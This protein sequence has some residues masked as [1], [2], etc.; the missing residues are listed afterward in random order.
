[1]SLRKLKPVELRNLEQQL[2]TNRKKFR[3]KDSKIVKRNGQ[4][5]GKT[6]YIISEETKNKLLKKENL[7]LKDFCKLYNNELDFVSLDGMYNKLTKNDMVRN[8]CYTKGW[9]KI[10]ESQRTRQGVTEVYY[11]YSIP[12]HHI[13]NLLQFCTDYLSNKPLDN[14]DEIY[15]MIEKNKNSIKNPEKLFESSERSHNFIG[16]IKKIDKDVK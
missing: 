15:R 7:K 3:I 10:R 2:L 9:I 11:L 4:K 8:Y 16:M 12:K 1:M 6:L 5:D 13:Q 14:S